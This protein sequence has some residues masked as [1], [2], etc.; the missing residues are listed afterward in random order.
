MNLSLSNSKE[1]ETSWIEF[2]TQFTGTDSPTALQ[3]NYITAAVIGQMGVNAAQ[4][5]GVVQKI[6]F[7]NWN[8]IFNV[9]QGGSNSMTPVDAVQALFLNVTKYANYIKSIVNAGL[10]P[11]SINPLAT[12]LEQYGRALNSPIS[13]TTDTPFG[14]NPSISN[15][16]SL[17][18]SKLLLLLLGLIF[19]INFF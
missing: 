6:S 5:S 4:V 2:E 15:D 18:K 16:L 1:C 7:S 14:N 17:F 9:S 19:I 13:Q 11:G 8:I 3:L 12:G 10:I